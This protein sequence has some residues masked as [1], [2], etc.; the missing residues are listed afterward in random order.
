M[1]KWMFIVLLPFLASCGYFG[2]KN[3]DNKI[4]VIISAGRAGDYKIGDKFDQIKPVNNQTMNSVDYT[5]S[6]G[7]YESMIFI[8]DNTIDMVK[9]I[10]TEKKIREIEVLSPLFKTK[11]KIGT[12]NNLIQLVEAYPD[13]KIKYSPE[14]ANFQAVTGQLKNVIFLIDTEM[15]KGDESIFSAQGETQLKTDDFQNE[16]KIVSIRI[17]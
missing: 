14:Y 5:N 16:A 15:Y 7:Q 8:K 6:K 4:G 9:L 17:F 11:E 1:A 13:I 10:V 12:G 3:N 2:N